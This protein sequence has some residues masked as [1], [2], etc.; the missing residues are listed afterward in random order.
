MLKLYNLS[1][2]FRITLD[3]GVELFLMKTAGYVM[4]FVEF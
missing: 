1:I 4:V 3:E 2:R